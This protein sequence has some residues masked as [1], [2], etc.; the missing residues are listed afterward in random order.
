MEHRIAREVLRRKTTTI[1][2]IS[3]A[4]CISMVRYPRKDLF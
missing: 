3:Q 4:L 2:C 1:L